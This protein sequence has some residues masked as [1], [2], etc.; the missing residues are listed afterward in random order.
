MKKFV[1]L[2]QPQKVVFGEKQ[3]NIEDI[4]KK[5]KISF[6]KN[7]RPEG[8]KL[9]INTEKISI[10]AADEAGAFYGRQTLNQLLKQCDD[11]KCP[12]VTIDDF[13]E[14]KLRAVMLDVSRD[15]MPT[16]EFIMNFV[17]QLSNW[18]VNT[19][20]LYIEHTFAY[21]DH[22]KVW[23]KAS[24][25]TAE[26][27]Q[28]LN[29]FCKERFITLVPC[30]NSLGHLLRWLCHEPYRQLAECPEGYGMSW[31]MNKTDPFSLCPADPASLKFIEG[32]MDE[33][34]PNFDCDLFMA[35]CDETFDI[36]KGR[37]RELAPDIS[38]EQLYVD[39]I[40]KLNEA[41]KKRN[42]KLAIFG[43]I[44]V[45]KQADTVKDFSKDIH[46]IDWGYGRNYEFEKHGKM[47]AEAGLEYSFMASNSNYYT[48][49]GRT[50]RAFGNIANAAEA[51]VKTNA[52][53]IWVAEWGDSGH[54]TSWLTSIPPFAYG[55]AMSWSPAQN[56]EIDMAS[57]L[58]TF[59]FNID[60]L[61]SIII[62]MGKLYQATRGEDDTDNLFYILLN[63]H[64][65]EKSHPF[66]TNITLDNLDK[67]KFDVVVLEHRLH[68]LKNCPDEIRDEL[69][70][71]IDFIKLSVKICIE[72][73]KDENIRF[74]DQ[75]MPKIQY[76]NAP[77]LENIFR[78][79]V[80]IRR[81]RYQPGGI[82]ASIFWLTKLWQNV[83][84]VAQFPEL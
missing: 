5:L 52:A 71:Y 18:K 60:G 27:I 56:K 73:V 66:F 62:D 8:Y 2:P 24:P 65:F 81:E 76:E 34:L 61:A 78:R 77:A 53:G 47:F 69:Q 50:Y 67:T 19:F 80:K 17:D 45:Q 13:P 6:D 26:D 36:G 54:W 48:I 38:K 30:Q 39:Y 32:L 42:H 41:T 37:S 43:D 1:F 49:G 70:I 75:L 21:K 29:A 57:C 68:N 58:D 59:V 83:C 31:S 16:L 40:N 12:E 44:I 51:A 55:A 28:K 25:L 14:L 3:V 35:G 4:N 15:K 72:F 64:R 46:I 23:E 7:L 22:K 79:L 84:D 11:N 63:L 82:D 33:L 10:T 20:M 74:V 9:E